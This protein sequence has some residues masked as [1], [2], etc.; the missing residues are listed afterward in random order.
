MRLT[1]T[2]PDDIAEAARDLAAEAD[3]SVSALVAEAIAE[4]VTDVRRRRAAERIQ[5]VMAEAE[6]A[7][8]AVQVL[9]QM[10]RE[11]DRPVG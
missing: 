10:R 7:P 2:V 6:V 1:V 4:Y 8:D 9:E 11:S 3:T 5:A